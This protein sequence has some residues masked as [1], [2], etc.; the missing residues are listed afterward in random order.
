LGDGGDTCGN[1]QNIKKFLQI[2]DSERGFGEHLRSAIM[3]GDESQRQEL[4]QIFGEEHTAVAPSFEKLIE[5]SM[6]QFD[7]DVEGY[8][9]GKTL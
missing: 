7:E 1:T 3:L 2:N 4:A 6:K 5:K 8:V 9:A